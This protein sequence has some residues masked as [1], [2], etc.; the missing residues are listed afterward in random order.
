MTMTDKLVLA[1]RTCGFQSFSVI[2]RQSGSVEDK[3]GANFEGRTA[4]LRRV[5][6]DTRW[7]TAALPEGCACCDVR[8]MHVGARLQHHSGLLPY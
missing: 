3:A 6:R 1:R 8:V 7:V 4:V 5:K 2:F